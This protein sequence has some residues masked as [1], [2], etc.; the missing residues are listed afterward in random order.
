MNNPAAAW[1]QCSIYLISQIQEFR[2][3]QVFNYVQ[4]RDYVVGFGSL[5][6]KEG[7]HIRVSH[8]SEPKQLRLF[9]LFGGT[10]DTGNGIEAA[11]SK[12]ME[13]RAIPATKVEN[14]CRL[15]IRKMRANQVTKIRRALSSFVFWLDVILVRPVP[16]IQ[17][18]ADGC[19]LKLS[20]WHVSLYPFTLS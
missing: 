7:R 15:V 6:R 14:S 10:V 17:T 11:L 3:C 2:L 5:T 19:R 4:C 1:R 20:R 12:K 16:S 13:Q 9:G 8:L 18:L